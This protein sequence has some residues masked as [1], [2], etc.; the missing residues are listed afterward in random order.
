MKAKIKQLTY[1]NIECRIL[2]MLTRQRHKIANEMV[3]NMIPEV[4]SVK[5]SE[6]INALAV[7]INSDIK[8]D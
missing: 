6:L 5:L 1:F 2:T 4:L 3:I 8:Y 7:N